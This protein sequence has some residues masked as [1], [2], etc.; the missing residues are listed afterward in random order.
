MRNLIQSA[1]ALGI[2]ILASASS[3]SGAGG[4]AQCNPKRPDSPEAAL[5]ELLAGNARWASGQPIHPGIDP[6]RRRCV[7]VEGQT[8]FAAILSCSDSRGPSEYIFDQGVGDLFVVRNAGNSSDDLAEQ[9]LAYAVEVLHVP[10]VVVMGHQSCGAVTGAVDTYPAS[11]P[12][13]ISV[14]Y[15]AVKQARDIIVRR[16]GSPDDKR[17]LTAETINQHVILEVQKLVQT[18]PFKEMI[19]AGKLKVVGGR[20]DLES[21]RFVVLTK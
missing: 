18:H 9:S 12:R 15:D 21:S 14:I 13:F 19:A 4:G 16:G 11:A 1:I 5:N 2:S 20:Y 8:P 6:S 3:A 10:V 7:F 17:A